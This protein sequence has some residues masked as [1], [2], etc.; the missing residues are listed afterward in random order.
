MNYQAIAVKQYRDYIVEPVLKELNMHSESA[1]RLVLGTAAQESK[2][3]FVKQIGGGPA[4]GL[5]QMEPATH[6]DIWQN[7]LAYKQKLRDKMLYGIGAIW[8]N[9]MPRHHLLIG[10]A[11]YATAMCRLHYRRVKAWLPQKDNIEQLAMYWKRHYNTRLGKGTIDEFV[12]SY[13]TIIGE[14]HA[15]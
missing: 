15:Q 13:Y 10:N 7:Y 4:L 2:F 9:D 11:F 12:H 6:D 14:N 1:V 3:D 8:H 5:Y